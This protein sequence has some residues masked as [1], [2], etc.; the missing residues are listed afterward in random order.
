MRSR[1]G[2]IQKGLPMKVAILFALGM[3]VSIAVIGLVTNL[4]GRLAGDVGSTGEIIL[5]V[6]LI[7]VGLSITG[8]FQIPIPGL[9][10][11]AVG[12]GTPA[13]V[14]GLVFGA[15]L[16][17]CTFA[18]MAPV[19]A[20]MFT[21]ESFRTAVFLGTA[22]AVGHAGVVLLMGAFAGRIQRVVD[23]SGQSAF[24]KGLRTASGILVV[25]GGLYL[26]VK[27]L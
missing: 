24:A 7:A 16:G 13:L 3:T 11:N 19:L 23:W 10:M 27:A 5:A 15:A 12:T 20:V 4:L 17:P 6:I 25:L 18:F 26:V 1:G 21:T 9:N 14:L 8:L 2:S 22:F